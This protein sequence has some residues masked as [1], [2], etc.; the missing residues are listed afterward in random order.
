MSVRQFFIEIE[1][2]GEDLLLLPVFFQGIE[3]FQR[4]PGSKE[5]SILYR[6]I[7]LPSCSATVTALP[8]SYCEVISCIRGIY[9]PPLVAGVE[10][11]GR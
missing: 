7:W 9:H 8:L 1:N 2:I 4:E 3:A 5:S 10:G 6:I 11:S